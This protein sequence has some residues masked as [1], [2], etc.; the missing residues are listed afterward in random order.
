VRTSG[1]RLGGWAWLDAQKY[2]HIRLSS[3]EAVT[4]ANA[5]RRAV[6]RSWS[7]ATTIARRTGAAGYRLSGEAPKGRAARGS[8]LPRKVACR[9]RSRGGRLERVQGH[10]LA[11][12]GQHPYASGRTRRK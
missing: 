6:T 7:M 9:A 11:H 2:P 10:R 4:A 5:T 3:S 8:V 12:E 1:G